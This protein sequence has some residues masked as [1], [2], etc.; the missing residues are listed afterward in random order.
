MR[1]VKREV[2]TSILT[3]CKKSS[4]V[5]MHGEDVQFY[6]E[7]CN[8]RGEKVAGTITMPLPKELIE[9]D[10]Q[11][12]FQTLILTSLSPEEIKRILDDEGLISEDALY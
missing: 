2:R 6:Y 1:G 7:I 8:L 4:H 10:N 5:A 9:S 3:I 12:T 11:L